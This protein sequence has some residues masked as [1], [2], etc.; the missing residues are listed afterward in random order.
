MKSLQIALL[1]YGKMGKI[2]H[3]LAQEAGHTIAVIIDN[4]TDWED[5]KKELQNVDVAIDFSMPETAVQNIKKCFEANIPVVV[6]TTGWYDHFEQIKAD[7]I[8]NKHSLFYASNFSLGVNIFSAINR[9]LAQIMD[10][11]PQYKVSMTETH[12]T[13]KKDA[14]SGTAISLANEIIQ[15]IKTLDTW[16][17]VNNAQ[18]KPSSS[19]ALPI[20]ALRIENV[21]GTHVISYTSSVDELKISHEAYSREGFAR[22]AITAAEWLVGKIGVF[23]MKDLLKL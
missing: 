17:L 15:E 12:H 2:I 19:N 22:G 6:G 1:G 23:N 13:Q 7:C 4:T 20:E 5:K 11:F 3:K 9:K 10:A 18:A 8:Q 21:P 16:E 14:P